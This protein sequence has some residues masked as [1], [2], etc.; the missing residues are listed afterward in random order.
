MPPRPPRRRV[1]RR[2]FVRVRGADRERRPRGR[3]RDGRGGG[4][5]DRRE[6]LGRVSCRFGGRRGCRCG[7]RGP[8]D[9]RGRGGGDRASTNR[10][11][12]GGGPRIGVVV[13]VRGARARECRRGREHDRRG[14]RRAWGLGGAPRPSR[15]RREW[16]RRSRRTP[17]ARCG[18]R[19]N[20][21]RD[22]AP[23]SPAG[24]AREARARCPSR[25][26]ARV[27]RA[28]VSARRHPRAARAAPPVPPRRASF[29][30]PSFL[31]GRRN[32][33]FSLLTRENERLERSRIS[34]PKPRG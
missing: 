1:A 33:R 20:A 5:F 31:F 27:T 9:V 29:L 4:T 11:R 19:E 23:R 28:S 7:R 13:C 24:G 25:S 17:R 26:D 14:E 21:S 10:R 18:T 16:W 32:E 12:R 15:R 30:G 34:D 22:G 2:S 3:R 8:L 6:T